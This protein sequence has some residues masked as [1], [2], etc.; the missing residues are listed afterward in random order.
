MHIYI[1]EI[2]QQITKKVQSA[3]YYSRTLHMFWLSMSH[4][5][6]FSNSAFQMLDRSVIDICKIFLHCL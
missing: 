1:L 3:L 5:Q 2:H 4:H 6:G